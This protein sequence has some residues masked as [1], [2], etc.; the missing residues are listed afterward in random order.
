MLNL[1]P[2]INRPIKTVA[3]KFDGQFY[4]NSAAVYCFF[5]NGFDP[6]RSVPTYVGNVAKIYY[7]HLYEYR[8]D[9]Y[10][11]FKWHTN[12]YTSKS[13]SIRAC[14]N[15]LREIHV[16]FFETYNILFVNAVETPSANAK[17]C[18]FVKATAD[19]LSHNIMYGAGGIGVV[20]FKNPLKEDSAFR[21]RSWM[22]FMRMC[23]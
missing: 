9:R 22:S 19:F 7:L 14:T 15:A 13:Y 21:I 17:L 6:R 20:V 12:K 16:I 8:R 23:L 1:C 2:V 5:D 10:G 11:S 3:F 4:I 18:V